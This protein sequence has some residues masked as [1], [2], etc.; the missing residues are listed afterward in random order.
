LQ[1]SK[2]FSA[3]RRRPALLQP[4]SRLSSPLRGV[5]RLRQLRVKKMM[6]EMPV[7]ETTIKPNNVA[8]N[9]VAVRT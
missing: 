5:T 4:L 8:F 6:I 9:P 2:A 7:A 3:L 1:Q